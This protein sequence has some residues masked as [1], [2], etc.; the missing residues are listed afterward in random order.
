MIKLIERLLLNVSP[1]K[2]QFFP[3]EIQIMTRTKWL[4]L[5]DGDAQHGEY[6]ERQIEG[7]RSRLFG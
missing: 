1:G 3:Y 2:K 4:S 5:F 7:V 6:V